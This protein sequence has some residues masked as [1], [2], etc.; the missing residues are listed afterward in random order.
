MRGSGRDD[1]GAGARIAIAVGVYV[2]YI[3][4]EYVVLWFS[5]TREYHADRFAGQVTGDASLIPTAWPAG[6]NRRMT[7]RPGSAAPTWRRSAPW[8]S[9]TPAPPRR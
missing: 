3:V 7:P 5:R 6:R 4:S 8:A 1:K 9:S 2:L